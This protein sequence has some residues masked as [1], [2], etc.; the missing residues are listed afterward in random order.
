MATTVPSDPLVRQAAEPLQG[1]IDVRLIEH[2]IEVDALR[3]SLP[4]LERVI[5][6]G[7]PQDEYEGWLAAH[8]PDATVYPA[9]P[10]HWRGRS[11]SRCRDSFDWSPRC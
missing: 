2:S 8:E 11:Q 1:G 4:T 5:R 7:G 3:P 6:V 10:D 9:N